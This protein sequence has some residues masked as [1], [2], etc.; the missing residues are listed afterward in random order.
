M[1]TGT[2]GNLPRRVTSFVGRADEL[3]R[4]ADALEDSPVVTL[5]GV[6]GVGKTRL[7]VEVAA[8]AASEYRDGA[9]LCEL[10]TVRDPDAVPDALVEVFGL[11]PRP[12]VTATELVL[13]FLRAKQLLVVLDNCEHLLKP[14]A[15]LVKRVVGECPGVR[16]LTTSREGLNVAGERILAVPSLELPEDPAELDFIARTDAVRLF[17]ERAGA[18][19]AGFA[20]D[21]T[22]AAAVAQICRRL[23]GVPLAI[24]LA[25]ARIG[26]L[27]PADLARRLD[28]RFRI[29]TGSERGAVERHQT[30]RAAIDWSY[31]LLDDAGRT[32]LGRLSVFAGGFTLAAAEAVASGDG[33]EG[34]AV[35]ELLAGLVA[36]SLV[37]ADTEGI[38]TRYRLLETIRQYAGERLRV[39]GDTDRVR[40]RHA[41]YY[42]AFGETAAAGIM[43]PAELEWRQRFGHELDNLR[44]ALAWAIEKSDVDTTLRLLALDQQ[45]LVVFSPELGV[46]LRSAAETAL[47]I[48]GLADD[49]RYPMV[50]VSLGIQCQIR[51]DLEEATRYCDDAVAAEKRLGIEPTP[52]VPTTRV[53]VA[54]TEG[55]VD[56][57]VEHAERALAICRARDDR[58]ELAGA[59]T[60][61]AM[62]HAL[63]GDDMEVASSEID[64]ALEIAHELGVP[65]LLGGTSAS[66]AFVLADVDPERARALMH[67]A[68]GTKEALHLSAMPQ[69]SMLGD[70]AERLGERRHALELFT[71]G[72][73]EMHWVGHTEV[74]GR[75][76]RRVGLGLVD[77][78]PEE[79]ALLI[80]A[81]TSFSH[82]WTLTRRVVEDQERG[83]Q[84]L[85]AAL[86]AD[87]CAEL[88][89]QG[90]CMDEHDVVLIAREAAERALAAGAPRAAPA[91]AGAPAGNV[92]RREGDVWAI[93]YD[94]TG[95]R[96]RDAKGLRYLARLLAEPG[97]E[98]H[99]SDLAADGTGEAAPLQGSVGEVLDESAKVTYRRRLAELEAEVA[100]ATEWN[101][102]ERVARAQDE[103]DA[104]VEQLAGAYGLG[105][106]ARTMGDQ[107][108]RIRKAVTNRIRD[109]LDRITAEHDA[110]GRHLANAIHTGTFCSYT[111]ERPTP[112]EL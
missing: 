56:Q 94:G 74:V 53:F 15:E 12:G 79:A 66:A 17:A 111:P 10:D 20:L 22:N 100:E 34:D 85:N 24:E 101:D 50:L 61:A 83:I 2:T 57:F 42:A 6:G 67:Q 76:L 93:A 52:A 60:Q 88:M 98:V 14:V 3:T 25:A 1:P 31:E 64:E 47:A 84:A 103:I 71:I 109:S 91:P 78:A 81:G 73:N 30:L 80:G 75:M 36:R 7:A 97:R 41:H 39:A 107:S 110:L 38:E 21:S 112:W 11:E 5:T 23:D 106:R 13:K 28:E 16:V 87:R 35:F 40:D 69:Y 72:M 95:I 65:S 90:S 49:P 54:V 19:R 104:L 44:V 26:M 27:T 82:G 68:L 96:L 32:L 105:G 89:A 62:G 55:L 58:V 59:L 86:G 108:E 46:M 77:D 18:V 33:I 102:T 92:F 70:V 4:V 43:S 29:L 63:R 45:P 37:E 99:V 48:P 8:S 9:W 51:G